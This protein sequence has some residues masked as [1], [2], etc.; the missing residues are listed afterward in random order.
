MKVAIVGNAVPERNFREEIDRCDLI[1][2]MGGMPYRGNLTGERTNIY[3]VHNLDQ[4]LLRGDPVVS[5]AEFDDLWIN[6]WFASY[7]IH[8]NYMLT[9]N[10]WQSHPFRLLFQEPLQLAAFGIGCASTGMMVIEYITRYPIAMVGCPNPELFLFC[11]SWAGTVAHQWEAE[12]AR[13]LD[14]SRRGR[15]IIR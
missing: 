5:E 2:R 6:T 7:Q 8:V 1:V 3:A 15:I 11:F 9:A 13:C 10:G 12:R 4:P 14:L